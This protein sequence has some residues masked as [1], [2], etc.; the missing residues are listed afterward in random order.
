MRKLLLAVLVLGVMGLV[1]PAWAGDILAVPT[2]NMVRPYNYE[3]NYIYW[4][5][6]NPPGA[7]QAAHIFENFVGVTDRLELDV[8]D[9]HL[10]GMKDYTE[11]NAYY[12]LIP[13]TATRPSLI[14]GVNN[15]FGSDWPGND[16]VSPFVLSS[17]NILM[18]KGGP[19]SLTNPVVR[20]HAAYGWQAN[21]DDPFGGVQILVHPKLGFAAFNYCRQ[22]AYM[23][24]YQ[25]TK[26]TALRAG[27][28][29]GTPFGSLGLYLD[30]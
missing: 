14:V 26:T 3:F 6:D 30:F 20:L 19:P 24:A 23:A 11:I 7:P 2:G 1:M 8:I 17:Y 28:K 18:P 25:A 10:Q 15:L 9:M 21:G 4:Q 13:E 27:W 29:N 22:P 16:N 12:S 5:F